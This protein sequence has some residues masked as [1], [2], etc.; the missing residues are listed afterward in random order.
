MSSKDASGSSVRFA[1]SPVI[2]LSRI[3][4]RPQHLHTAGSFRDSFQKTPEDKDLRK[5]TDDYELGKKLGTGAYS[6]VRRAVRRRDGL[7]VAI[8]CVDRTKLNHTELENLTREV[9]IMQ[10]F[11]HREVT[12]K[13][14]TDID[15]S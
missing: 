13:P 3:A 9:S 7:V 4:V 10:E 14:L 6:V 11:L 2:P 15:S 12:P 1:P 5:V 8:K